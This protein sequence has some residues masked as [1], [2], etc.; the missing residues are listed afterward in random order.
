V[1]RSGGIYS[2]LFSSYNLTTVVQIRKPK[3]PAVAESLRL[4]EFDFPLPPG[5]LAWREH[6]DSMGSPCPAYT[7][8]AHPTSPSDTPKAKSASPSHPIKPLAPSNVHGDPRYN[9]NWPFLGSEVPTKFWDANHGSPLQTSSCL[10]KGAEPILDE[11]PSLPLPPNLWIFSEVDD[12]IDS[13]CPSYRTNPMTP[14]DTPRSRFSLLSGRTRLRAQD[15]DGEPGSLLNWSDSDSSD[16]APSTP[17][18]D[19]HKFRESR[20]MSPSSPS[21]FGKFIKRLLRLDPHPR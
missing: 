12:R 4:D 6:D 13:P 21:A 17:A 20:L 1:D 8:K 2:S 18:L 19:S 16:S 14:S 3:L 9:A 10:L 11:S 15:V 5:V 7:G